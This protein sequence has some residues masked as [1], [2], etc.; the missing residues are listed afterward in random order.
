MS[1][2]VLTVQF[3]D[4]FDPNV[5]QSNFSNTRH[6]EFSTVICTK[7]EKNKILK[8]RRMQNKT[9]K[10]NQKNDIWIL[11]HIYGAHLTMKLKTIL[12]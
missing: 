10:N 4:I 12:T 8:R 6:L 5:I 9:S 2:E 1:L 3:M 11:A 7:L